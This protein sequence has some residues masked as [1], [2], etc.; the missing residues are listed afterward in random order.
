MTGWTRTLQGRLTA[1]Y[2]IAFFIGLLAFAAVSFAAMDGAL[3]IITDD[4]LKNSELPMAKVL[5]AG[6]VSGPVTKERLDLLV[7]STR[8]GAVFSANGR[9]VYSSAATVP[10]SM[11]EIIMQAGDAPRLMA[12]RIDGAAGRVVTQRIA[13]RD[14]SFAYVGIW[15]QLDLV[16][17]L[18]R[19]AAL[20]LAAAVVVIGV[21]AIL[22]G[23]LVARAGLRPLSAVATL[24]SEIEAH[25]LSRRIGLRDDPSELGRLA[26]TFDRMLARLEDAFERQRRF[27]ADASHELRAPLSVIHVAADLA[28]RREREPA[29]YRRV[30]ASILRATQQLESLTDALLLAARADAAH[31]DIE[32]VEVS[33]VVQEALEHLS[34]LLES[35]HIKLVTSLKPA[36]FIR[37]DRSG[38]G[39]V[40]IA[41][42]DN[43]IKFSREG[44]SLVASVS[45]ARGRVR[46]TLQDEGPG[47]SD[48][49]LLRATDR[50]WRSDAARVP[51]KGSGLGLAISDTIVRAS[52]GTLELRN[53]ATGGALVVVEFSAAA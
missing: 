28:L 11:R 19:V 26:T 49:G 16:A 43:A 36:T 52:G 44:G 3:K 37:A 22:V 21:S 46:L 8:T 7:G 5:N 48:E 42:V 4:R 32:R 23:S 41:L 10:P 9:T 20:T 51:G 34:P 40:I 24:A 47:F 30:L 45:E 39:R 31:A 50:F 33:T 13:L 29:A 27:T 53:A 14:G 15:R 2:A 1:G 25:D 18:E 35:K 12:L 6:P 17:E 38:L